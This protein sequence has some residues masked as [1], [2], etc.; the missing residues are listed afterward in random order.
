MK[1]LEMQ[2]NYNDWKEK[3][4]RQ[5]DVRQIL[6]IWD[7]FVSENGGRENLHANILWKWH[8]YLRESFIKSL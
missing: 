8:N 3:V 1:T 7:R 5:K 2:K 4:R 6:S